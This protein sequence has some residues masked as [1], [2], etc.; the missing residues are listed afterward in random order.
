MF[1]LGQEESLGRRLKV[2]GAAVALQ[3]GLLDGGPDLLLASDV[4][5]HELL[6]LGRLGQ[7][8]VDYAGEN[9]MRYMGDTSK[10]G[11]T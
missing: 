1:G 6:G 5:G 3:D 7:Q 2:F 8:E 9:L 10:Y 11:E 4:L